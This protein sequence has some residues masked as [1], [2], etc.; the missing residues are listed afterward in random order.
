MEFKSM[1]HLLPENNTLGFRR[2]QEQEEKPWSLTSEFVR[3]VGTGARATVQSIAELPNIIPGVDYEVTVPEFTPRP[4]TTGGNIAAGLVQFAVPYAA[5]LRGISLGSKLFGAGRAAKTAADAARTKRA[6]EVEHAAK[7]G[8]LLKDAVVPP[9]RILTRKEKLVK[10]AGAGAAADFIAFSPNDP[11]LGNF[12]QGLGG[13]KVPVVNAISNL[14]ATDEDDSD[15]LNRFRHVLEGLG[16]GAA[17]PMVLKGLGKGL[18][19]SGQAVKKTIPYAK[20]ADGKPIYAKDDFGNTIYKKNKDGSNTLDAKGELIPEQAN[21]LQDFRTRKI[22]ALDKARLHFVDPAQTFKQIAEEGQAERGK[23]AKG[24]EPRQNLNIHEE[25]RMLVAHDKNVENLYKVGV[26]RRLKDGNM[27]KLPSKPRREIEQNV[28]KVIDSE[29]TRQLYNDYLYVLQA[30]EHNV[31]AKKSRIDYDTI[32][33][34]IKRV[35]ALPVTIKTVFKQSI[36]DLRAV[37]RD[38]LQVA[39]EEGMLDKAA[40]KSMGK[41]T[42]GGKELDRLYIPGLRQGIDDEAIELAMSTYART[43]RGASKDT[44][45]RARKDPSKM[46]PKR[47]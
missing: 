3:A 22:A 28:E 45:H 44:L 23:S 12:I 40:L 4:Q 24:T 21:W 18:S 13:D 14:L 29:D 7:S 35:E 42:L 34:V 31:T 8:E 16:L 27:Q 19:L 41:V 1:A 9:A 46:K 17:I 32:K 30:L 20:D 10:Y 39:F 2:R 38:M 6:F 25:R 37:N 15:A 43:V 11:T 33:L 47:I 26:H 5:V 36:T